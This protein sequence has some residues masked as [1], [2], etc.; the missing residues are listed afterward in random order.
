MT[1]QIQT[2]TSM[3]IS[4]PMAYKTLVKYYAFTLALAP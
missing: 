1:V 4:E 3:L 2:I